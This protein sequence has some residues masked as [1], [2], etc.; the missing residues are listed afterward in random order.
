M[1]ALAS[2]TGGGGMSA[3]GGGPSEATSTATS[4]INSAFNVT[5]GGGRSAQLAPYVAIGVVVLAW[6]YFNRKR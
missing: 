6:L 2:L 3:G 5:F 4:G 1:A